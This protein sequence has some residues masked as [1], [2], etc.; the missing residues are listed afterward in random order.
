[1]TLG[2]ATPAPRNAGLNTD[3]KGQYLMCGISSALFA[4]ESNLSQRPLGSLLCKDEPS[5]SDS[6][7]VPYA[8]RGEIFVKKCVFYAIIDCSSVEWL[9]LC[10][11]SVV[12]VSS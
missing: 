10:F 7:L 4:W 5:E 2:T 11:S 9:E 3:I 12:F 6:S 1:M 8:T